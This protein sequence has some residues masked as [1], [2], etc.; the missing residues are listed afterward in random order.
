MRTKHRSHHIAFV[1]PLPPSINHQYA[2]VYGRRVLSA[3][4][5]RYK[6]D[7][8]ALLLDH[9]YPARTLHVLTQAPR[10][11]LSLSFFFANNRRDLDGGLKIAQDAIC[12]AL[13]I[14][15]IRIGELHLYKALDR[16]RPRLEVIL[17]PS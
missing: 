16:N 1:L 17:A 14:N 2:T 6:R 5:R 12:E 15:D 9:R 3:A 4:A 11:S 7:V 8:A 10:L 13:G